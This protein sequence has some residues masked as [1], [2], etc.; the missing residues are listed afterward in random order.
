MFYRR[1]CLIAA[2]EINQSNEASQ[3]LVDP[4]FEGTHSQTLI[5]AHSISA[6]PQGRGQPVDFTAFVGGR[7]RTRAAPCFRRLH[8]SL[9]R[10]P[11]VTTFVF[12]SMPHIINDC[13]VW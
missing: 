4:L 3:G 10:G 7:S 11:P 9:S 8:Y 2:A 6:V 13:L 5:F 1:H 12:V